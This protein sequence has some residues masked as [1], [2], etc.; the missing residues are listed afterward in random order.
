MVNL[1]TVS[2]SGPI[3]SNTAPSSGILVPVSYFF[4]VSH[5]PSSNSA[6]GAK[7]LVT[8]AIDMYAGS[9]SHK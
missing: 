2:P 1:P 4:I 5:V 8:L 7:L 9:V 3:T 6:C